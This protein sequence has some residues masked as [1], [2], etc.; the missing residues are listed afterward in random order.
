MTEGVGQQF[1]RQQDGLVG[2]LR[3]FGQLSERVENRAV[4]L[5]PTDY[6]IAHQG[7]VLQ[8]LDVAPFAAAAS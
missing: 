6:L 4:R 3:R 5:P 1:R 7:R 8:L 2:R